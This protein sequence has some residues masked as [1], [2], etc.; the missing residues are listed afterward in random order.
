MRAKLLILTIILSFVLGLA[1]FA[2]GIYVNFHEAPE[3][4]DYSLQTKYCREDGAC[5]EGNTGDYC[6]H[7]FL[8][9]LSCKRP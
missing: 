7:W 1:V 2:I 3:N 6:I 4:K 9:A 8:G 5:E